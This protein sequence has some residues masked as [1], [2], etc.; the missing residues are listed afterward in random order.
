MVVAATT[1]KVWISFLRSA[2]A[3]SDVFMWFMP[4]AIAQP[5]RAPTPADGV[6]E[7]TRFFI[8]ATNM[9]GSVNKCRNSSLESM[10]SKCLNILSRAESMFLRA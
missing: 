10:L 2:V 3:G 7:S 8:S 1:S 9:V 6:N 4:L 5:T